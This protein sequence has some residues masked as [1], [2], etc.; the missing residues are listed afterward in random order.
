[1]HAHQAK[2]WLCHFMLMGIVEAGS[3]RLQPDPPDPAPSA[4]WRDYI[5]EQDLFSVIVFLL[6]GILA[7]AGLVYKGNAQKKTWTVKIDTI[8]FQDGEG[9]P[10]EN[11]S[12]VLKL[13]TVKPSQF[14]IPIDSSEST[15]IYEYIIDA[16]FIRSLTFS[17]VIR[18]GNIPIHFES[19]PVEKM[20][21]NGEPVLAIIPPTTAD[22]KLKNQI[23]NIR[24]TIR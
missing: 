11:L 2:S 7:I 21:K 20:F 13:N 16:K 3:L 6:V 17:L 19:I 12:A 24:Y 23:I 5:S 10:P 4:S 9:T 15:E 18:D 1:M 14:V 8:S 22:P